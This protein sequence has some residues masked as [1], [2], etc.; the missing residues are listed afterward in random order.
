MYS[1]GMCGSGNTELSR[2]MQVC[3]V[4]ACGRGMM[5]GYREVLSRCLVISR[6]VFWKLSGSSP[7]D[8]MGLEMAGLR[9]KDPP[10]LLLPSASCGHPGCTPEASQKRAG[11]SLGL[12]ELS[13]LLPKEYS[14]LAP[15]ARDR[16][17]ENNEFAPRS[18][19][20]AQVRTQVCLCNGLRPVS[21]SYY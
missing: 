8:G 5:T 13:F 6:C 7:T 21:R 1:G 14:P 19:R 9:G 3:C 15:S 18:V 20:G 16:Q 10:S 17:G 4:Q 11:A 12:K 2:G